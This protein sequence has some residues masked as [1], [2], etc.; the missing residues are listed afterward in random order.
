MKE[1]V[2]IKNCSIFFNREGGYIVVMNVPKDIRAKLSAW[3]EMPDTND[4]C[5]T[6]SK[7]AKAKVAEGVDP[8]TIELTGTGLASVKLEA[9]E[10]D[11]KYKGKEGHTKKWQ[12]IGILHKEPLTSGELEGLEDD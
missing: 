4:M 2:I 3:C 11:W 9:C 7:Y 1:R 6:V 12:V 10:Y 8:D 5:F